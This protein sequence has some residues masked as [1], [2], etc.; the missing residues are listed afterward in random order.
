MFIKKA[1]KGLMPLLMIT[2]GF[3][4]ADV[5]A[6]GTGQSIG[7]IAKTASA[8]LENVLKLVTGASYLAGFGLTI[9]SLFKFKKHH[10]SPQSQE[11]LSSCIMMLVVGIALIFLPSLITTGGATLGI[12]SAGSIGGGTIS[13]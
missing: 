4:A 11:T 5:L 6:T 7:D 2:V 3:Y 10:D 12:S 1:T 9:G 13:F 8:S